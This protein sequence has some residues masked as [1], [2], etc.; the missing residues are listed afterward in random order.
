[1][2]GYSELRQVLYPELQALYTGEKTAEEAVK[3]YQ[4]KG[5]EV[6]N[7]AKTSSVIYQ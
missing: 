3:D 4:T 6:I 5:N 1:M 2:P 7:N